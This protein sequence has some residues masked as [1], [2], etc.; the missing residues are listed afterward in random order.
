MINWRMA[1]LRVLCR[2]VILAV[3]LFS[4]CQTKQARQPIPTAIRWE[5]GRA[6]ALAI[7]KPSLSLINKEDFKQQVEFR[8]SGEGDQTSIAGDY[9]ELDTEFVFKPL[10]P[11]TRGLSYSVFFNQEFLANIDIP[12]SHDTPI[13][14]AFYPSVD[15]VP[16]NLL[17]LYFVFSK[18]MEEGHALQHIKL[19]DAAGDSL[20]NVFLNLQHELWNEEGTILTIWFDPG[21]IKR[22]L[23]PN[24]L[25]GPPLV[26]GRHYNLM[27]SP[28][29]TDQEAVPLSKRYSRKLF[30]GSRDSVS[31]SLLNWRLNLPTA[32][33]L[34]PLSIDLLEPLDQL[35]LQDAIR[36]VD[37]KGIT[38]KGSRS[39]DN[40]DRR[41][42]FHPDRSWIPGKYLLQVDAGLEDLAGNNLNRLFDVDL[43]K[44][45]EKP[46]AK[47][48]V[49][50]AFEIK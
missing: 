11:F 26:K 33:S 13:L 32:G 24:K 31:P 10:I 35:L 46:A 42:L 18:P 30:I 29:W 23:Q 49:E 47:P 8:R 41:F 25:L 16:E 36:L 44:Q 37:P 15:T 12:V 19:S 22:D 20:P 6:I 14:I 28:G 2:P 1:G 21:R 9:L 43:T 4:G 17:K 45:P 50:R 38:V 34:Q 48:F 40:K 3:F 5:H 39:L 27:I 7:P